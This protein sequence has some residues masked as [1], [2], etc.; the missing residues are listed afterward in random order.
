MQFA[1]NRSCGQVDPFCTAVEAETAEQ[2][3]PLISIRCGRS[4]S[5]LLVGPPFGRNTHRRGSGGAAG[6]PQIVELTSQR[7]RALNCFLTSG[8]S[9]RCHPDRTPRPLCGILLSCS[10]WA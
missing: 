7:G 6:L 5:G 4:S 10:R 9:E 2:D 8:S 3:L 1:A